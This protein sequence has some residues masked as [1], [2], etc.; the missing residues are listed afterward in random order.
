MNFIL[1]FILFF[2]PY[3][4][5]FASSDKIPYEVLFKKPAMIKALISPDGRKIAYLAS[6]TDHLN[7]FLSDI[8]KMEFKNITAYNDRDIIDYLWVN[9][10]EI[11]FTCSENDKNHI[12]LID[13]NKAEKIT[14]LTPKKNMDCTL[15]HKFNDQ[16]VIKALENKKNDLYIFDSKNKKILMVYKD[17]KRI[18][19]FLFDNKHDLKVIIKSDGYNK[20][21]YIKEK[22]KFKKTFECTF[23]EILKP[24][25]ISNDYKYLYFLS[26]IKT[27]KVGVYKI[28]IGK[29]EQIPIPVYLDSDFDINFMFYSKKSDKP[30]GIKYILEKNKYLFFDNRTKK[31]I[32]FLNSRFALCDLEFESISED[33][34]QMVLKIYN[35]K[36]QGFYYFF[37]IKKNMLKKIG[38]ISP[39]LDEKKLCSMRPIDLI[40]GD[41]LKI[42]GYITFPKCFENKPLPA[43]VAIHG[44]PHLRDYWKYSAY[45]QFFA[46][47]GFIVLQINYRGSLGYGK[48]FWEKS[49]GQWGLSM[50]S[51]IEDVVNWAIKKGYV[52]PDKI[53]LFGSSYGGFAVLNELIKN[54]DLYAAG[55]ECSGITD[56]L[57]YIKDA[58]RSSS[59]KKRL[60][61]TIG[62]PKKDKDKLIISSP[63]YNLDKIKVPLFIAH[64][65]KDKKV[66]YLHSATLS[67]ELNKKNKL[68]KFILEEKEGHFFIEDI[69]KKKI[70]LEIEQFFENHVLNKKK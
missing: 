9:N 25:Y 53:A 43:I 24:L 31:M 57:L 58:G 51:D 70:Y 54:P 49:F 40:A 59:Q 39:W 48:N 66:N 4:I 45:V 47:R 67:E 46:D 2:S 63:I 28:E 41:G 5:L 15:I 18:E 62:N 36:T 33:E 22:K 23:K 64:G 3:I 60:Y 55:V 1:T 65:K 26:N 13:I 6:Y 12:F 61:E 52:D 42:H 69:T 11:I 7:I 19:D 21:L 38:D 8:D 34:N 35:D 14:N 29:K 32:K 17:S 68:H 56:L 16:Y 44:G 50:Q 37:D 10:E 20:T 30:L 27:D